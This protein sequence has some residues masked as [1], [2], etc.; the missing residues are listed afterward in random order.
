MSENL[1]D[2]AVEKLTNAVLILI[3]HPGDARQRL[4]D[5]FLSIQTLQASDF[6]PGLQGQWLWVVKEMTKFGPVIDYNG[7][8]VRGAVEN[9]MRRIRNRTASKIIKVINDLYW[10]VSHNEQYH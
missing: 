4:G 10:A 5:A 3:S 2:Y 6:P 9:T 1:H 8:A 7:E